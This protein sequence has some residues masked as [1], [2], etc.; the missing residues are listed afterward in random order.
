MDNHVEGSAQ[1]VEQQESVMN[2]QNRWP[3][4]SEEEF[5]RLQRLGERASQELAE[6]DRERDAA[7]RELVFARQMGRFEARAWADA[8]L[9]AG[10]PM[11]VEPWVSNAAAG[12]MYYSFETAALTDAPETPEEHTRRMEHSIRSGDAER[13]AKTMHRDLRRHTYME[14]VEIAQWVDRAIAAG[15]AGNVE[16]WVAQQK[17]LGVTFDPINQ[18]L[19]EPS[20][21]PDSE[22]RGR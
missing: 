20:R 19:V 5:L 1:V 6:R 13:R 16:G 11:L 7:A 2:D 9:D 14:H 10:K 22:H 15:V 18:T 4:P 3:A 8:W 12:G 17:D 21:A